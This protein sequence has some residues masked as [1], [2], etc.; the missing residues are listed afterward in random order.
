LK[1]SIGEKQMT[2]LEF[3]VGNTFNITASP[4]A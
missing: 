1:Q 3:E 2:Q 4:H